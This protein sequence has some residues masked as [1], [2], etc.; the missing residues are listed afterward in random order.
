MLQLFFCYTATLPQSQCG[1]LLKWTSSTDNR[2]MLV[3]KKMKCTTISS[4]VWDRF[5][6]G[7]SS[8]VWGG[9]EVWAVGQQGWS[10][11]GGSA[12]GR[13]TTVS[14]V[15]TSVCQLLR[16]WACTLLARQY[17]LKVYLNLVLYSNPCLN[18]ELW[19]D[20]CSWWG[21]RTPNI[22]LVSCAAQTTYYR[23]HGHF[24]KR[25][26]R[27]DISKSWS[28]SAISVKWISKESRLFALLTRTSSSYS[29]FFPCVTLW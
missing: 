8:A 11:E 1:I 5:I 15:T 17:T 22:S 16:H 14:T 27:P 26:Q 23:W 25:G 24:L 9:S 13:V 10:A 21:W 19:N 20:I 3:C 6:L 28:L 2:R 29:S 12:A 18:K 7:A 4:M